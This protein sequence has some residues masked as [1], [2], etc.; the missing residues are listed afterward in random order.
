MD[1]MKI[2]NKIS[3][4]VYIIET[5]VYGLIKNPFLSCYNTGTKKPFIYKWRLK[6]FK[7]VLPGGIFDSSHGKI[8]VFL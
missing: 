7:L 5:F 8:K 1:F 2:N 3:V 6:N 4:Y